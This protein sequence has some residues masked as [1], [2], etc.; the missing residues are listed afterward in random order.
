MTT[1]AEGVEDEETLALLR[2]L[3]SDL[4]QG[5]YIG[6]PMEPALL[7]EWAAQSSWKNVA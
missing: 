3:G 2:E 7:A 4:A 1:I 6:K 5:Y